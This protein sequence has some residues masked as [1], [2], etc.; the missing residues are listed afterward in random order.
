MVASTFARSQEWGG[1]ETDG[2]SC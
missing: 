1:A 2:A